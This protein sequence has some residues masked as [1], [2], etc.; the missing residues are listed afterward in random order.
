VL[1]VAQMGFQ[2]GFQGTLCDLLGEMLEQA[3]PQNVFRG[4]VA[5]Q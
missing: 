3:S 1:G 2:L 5:L 4:G